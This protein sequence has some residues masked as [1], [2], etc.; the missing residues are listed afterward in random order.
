MMAWSPWACS[1]Q[2]TLYC[3]GAT[4]SLGCNTATVANEPTQS[5][6]QRLGQCVALTSVRDFGKLLCR[7][8]IER[9]PPE[10]DTKGDVQ[11]ALRKLCGE[12]FVE[13]LAP[14]LTDEETWPQD[15]SF[16]VFCRW[17]DWQHHA[18]LIDL[19]NEPL[20]DDAT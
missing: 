10:C 7:L 3:A 18:L 11:K 15:R 1:R 8:E 16:A 13:Q 12:I 9:P 14:W 17:F 4:R 20:T 2:R 5:C 6:D 19:C